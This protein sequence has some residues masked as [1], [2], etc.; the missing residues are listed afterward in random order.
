MQ[1]LDA[2]VCLEGRC[3]STADFE[4]LACRLLEPCAKGE[5]HKATT[6]RKQLRLELGRWQAEAVLSLYTEVCL[7]SKGVCS[8]YFVDSAGMTL[9]LRPRWPPS[10]ATPG[11]DAAPTL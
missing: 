8:R 7:R 5:A 10:P 6:I 2:S 4:P 3:P 11:S 9:R 1:P